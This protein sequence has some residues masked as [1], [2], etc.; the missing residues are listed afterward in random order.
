M[1]AKE[2]VKIVISTEMKAGSQSP[3]DPL[4]AK[5]IERCN[6]N[7]IVMHGADPKKVADVIMQESIDSMPSKKV[8]LGTRIVG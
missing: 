1:T 4:A 5:I 3:V 7:T 8:H 2:L 6:I